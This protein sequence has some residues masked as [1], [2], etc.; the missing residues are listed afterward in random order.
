MMAVLI[1]PVSVTD[2]LPPP[3]EVA[4]DLPPETFARRV[5]APPQPPRYRSR[6]VAATA[7]TVWV[8]AYQEALL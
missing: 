7:D 5:R 1:A 8:L 6:A 2:P 3:A 4:A